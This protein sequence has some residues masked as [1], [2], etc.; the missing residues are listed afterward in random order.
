MKFGRKPCLET[1]LNNLPPASFELKTALSAAQAGE[2][3]LSRY[4]ADL[5]SAAIE[6]KTTDD[7]YQ[8]IVTRADIEAERAVVAEILHA[9][10]NHEFLA[11]EEHTSSKDAEH[12]W[13]IDPLDGTNNFAHGIPHFAVSVA[14]YHHGQAQCGVVL[15]PS[16][17]D[18]FT[19][20]RGR[21]AWWNGIPVKVNQHQSLDQTMIAVGFYYDRGAMMKATLQAVEALFEKNI[22]GIRRFGTAALDIVQVGLGRFGGYFEYQLSPWDFAAARL[23]LEKQ[24]AASRLAPATHCHCRKH[25]SWQAIRS[26]IRNCWES[27]RNSPITNSDQRS[28]S[29]ARSTDGQRSGRN[30]P[31]LVKLPPTPISFLSSSLPPSSFKSGPTE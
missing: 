30:S 17:G 10:P 8:G 2:K 13:I 29:T 26:F 4:F 31:G 7:Q 14:Y 25:L 15:N 28:R 22:H 1:C 21:G 19:S 18:V 23:F 24:E 6:T 20:Q 27:S 16:T 12:L 11:E 5:A 9:F 3:I